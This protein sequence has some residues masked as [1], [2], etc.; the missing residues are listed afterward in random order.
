MT[1]LAI[2]AFALLPNSVLYFC[3]GFLLTAG[4][5]AF[6]YGMFT[7]QHNTGKFYINIGFFTL[8]PG[9]AM[10]LFPDYGGVSALIL[11]ILIICILWKI[12]GFFTA[13]FFS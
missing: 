13:L 9:A 1:K 5:G 11:F 8:L 7:K 3:G 12:G 6:F 10:A 2:L 4:T